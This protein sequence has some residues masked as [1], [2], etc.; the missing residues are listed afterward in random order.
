MARTFSSAAGS[1][2]QT[3]G[4]I[5]V[6]GCAALL[7]LLTCAPGAVW[8]DS[9]L[10]QYRV[11]HNDIEGNLGLALSH[12]VYYILAI[13]GKHVLPGEFGHK[14]TVVTALISA[15]A[16]ANL[17]LL[18]RLLVRRALP[19]LA[20][21]LSLALA[22][23]FWWHAT[24]PEIYN[25]AAALLFAE[26]ILLLQYA[27]TGRTGWLWALGFVNGVAV[28]NHM[29]ASIA[30]LC[31]AVVLVTLSLRREVRWRVAAIAGLLW[32]IGALPYEYLIVKNTFDQR[33]DREREFHV[34]G[35]ELSDAERTFG[36]GGGLGHI[37]GDTEALV[38]GRCSCA[39]GFV[40]GIR[41][42]VHGCGSVRVFHTFLLHG[43]N[44]DRRRCSGNQ[45]GA[46]GE[47]C[48]SGGIGAVFFDSSDVLFCA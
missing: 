6:F 10:I 38:R 29:V 41:V 16:V 48:G 43:F 12:P 7:Y 5:G 22:H 13:G 37:Q 21:A 31:Y 32:I 9:G 14:V 40:S 1:E 30:F 36:S 3:A 23:T 8:Q 27:R 18:L 19:A 11:W 4:Y 24:V 2:N 47:R 26:L 20:G 44:F 39:V 35:V 28:A 33:G 25:L 15:A 45:P 46:P 34:D 17:F 42:S